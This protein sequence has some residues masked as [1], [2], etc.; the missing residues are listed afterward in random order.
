MPRPWIPVGSRPSPGRT[1]TLVGIVIAAAVIGIGADRLSLDLASVT[2]AGVVGAA[3]LLSWAYRIAGRTVSVVFVSSVLWTVYFPIR[4]VLLEA[5]RT[6]PTLHPLVGTASDAE[7]VTCWLVALGGLVALLIGASAVRRRT[8]GVPSGPLPVGAY[9]AVALVGVVIGAVTLFAHISSG[10]LSNLAPLALF[11]L[12][13]ASYDDARRGRASPQTV[14]LLVAAVLLGT[15]AGM[16]EF[17]LLPVLACA[18]GTTAGRRANLRPIVVVAFVVLSMGAYLAV[19]GQRISYRAGHPTSLVSGINQALT[20]DDLRT[21]Y[22]RVKTK[23]GV[24][25]VQDLGVGLSTRLAGADPFIVLHRQVPQEEPF[26]HGQAII[27]PALSVLPGFRHFRDLRFQQLSLGRYFDRNFYSVQPDSDPSSQAI[28]WPGD[29]YL[30]FGMVG[31]AFG[32]VLIGAG[33]RWFDLRFTPTSA[34]NCAVIA[35]VGT[36]LVGVERN[37]AYVAVSAAIRL[38]VTLLVVPLVRWGMSR[39]KPPASERALAASLA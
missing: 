4:L 38:G 11:G 8:R 9:H 33:L 2:V 28:T 30:N 21:G 17:A 32:M 13:G 7:F 16:K 27:E 37:I 35:Y 23:R 39:S 12:A 14:V 24:S 18:V 20:K 5:D 25:I 34:P 15:A 10:F 22:R 36:M 1:Y 6:N 19:E 29:L 3:L 26:Q 31:I